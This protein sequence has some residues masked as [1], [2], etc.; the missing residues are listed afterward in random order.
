MMSQLPAISPVIALLALTLLGIGYHLAGVVAAWLFVRRKGPAGL[1]LPPVSILKPVR[2][3]D[4]DDYENYASFCRQDY[5]EFELLFGV[6]DP[7]DP[8]IDVV[9]RL[10][11]DFPERAIQLVVSRERIGQNL[12]VCNLQNMLAMARHPLLL[13]SDSDMWVRPDYLRS[14]V[15]YFNDRE[16][17]LVTSAYRGTGIRT[18]AAALEAVGIATSFFPGVAIATQFARPSFALGATIALRRRMLEQIGGFPGLA[19]YLADDFQLGR[20]VARAGHRVALSRYVVDTAV[21]N[22]GF[23]AMFRR[24]LRW[25][26]TARTCQPAGFAGSIIT[27]STVWA[28]LLAVAAQ[29]A[30]W[31]LAV[32]LAQQVIRTGAALWTAGGVLDSREA[33]RWLWLLPASDLLAFV[34]WAGSWCGNTVYWRGDRYRLTEGGRMTRLPRPDER[35]EPRLPEP[36]GAPEPAAPIAGTH[37]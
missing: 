12:K 30:P 31:A 13:I 4:V 19:D 29:G 25:N 5:P 28:V 7:D 33:V 1:E 36:A 10:Q 15:T 11:Q 34:L 21:P 24:T 20:R 16:I 35:S 2:G 6:Q 17:G 8:A 37:S 3:L 18:V 14:I 23:A 9:R 32:L 27:H 22:A 26:R